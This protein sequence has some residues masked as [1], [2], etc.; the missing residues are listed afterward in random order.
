[1]PA[2]YAIFH[3]PDKQDNHQGGKAP[4]YSSCSLL[5]GDKVLTLES[6]G[7]RYG[8]YL[9]C[10]TYMAQKAYEH[11]VSWGKILVTRA[12]H[13]VAAYSAISLNGSH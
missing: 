12:Q 1:M 13:P 9:N 7:C 4:S 11:A 6:L 3:Y 5:T 8:I 2:E 10:H